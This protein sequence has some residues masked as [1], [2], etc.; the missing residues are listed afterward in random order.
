MKRYQLNIV[1][2]WA[3]R[4]RYSTPTLA[5]RACSSALAVR[6]SKRLAAAW[7]IRMERRPKPLR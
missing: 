4:D 5:A 3:G 6:P 1:L 7:L 2:T